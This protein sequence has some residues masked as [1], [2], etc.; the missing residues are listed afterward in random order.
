MKA[1]RVERTGGPEVLE[2]IDAEPAA[3][4]AGQLA[5]RVAV[6]GVNYI[7]T[8]H[9]SGS[10]PQTPPFGLG[11]E[12]A[13]V[14]TAIG[15]DITGADVTGFAVGDRVAWWHTPLAGDNGS[16]AEHVVVNAASTVHVPDAVSDEIAAAVLLQGLTAHYLIASSYP[17]AAGDTVLVHAAAGGVG[18]LL[19]Q[20]AKARGAR[21]IATASTAEK[22]LLAKDNGADEVLGYDDFAAEVR[23]L[24][25]G[26]GV[27]VVYDGV[28]KDTFDDSLASLRPRG[29]LALYGASSGQVPPFDL[30]RLNPAGSLFV[31]RPTL[32]HHVATR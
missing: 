5:V 4:R 18:L 7:D 25:D 3:P 1:I 28:G 32:A 6:A 17:V 12:G 21:V 9:R 13:G 11:Q 26:V 16:Y 15:S 24:T 31:T 23:R 19:T 10:Y 22:R 20:L 2:L 14:I 8:Y 29:L 27:S 30:Q